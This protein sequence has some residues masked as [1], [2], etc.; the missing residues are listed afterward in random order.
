MAKKTPAELMREAREDAKRTQAE[1]ADEIGVSQVAVAKWE[2]GANSVD[3][4]RV[5]AVAKAYGLKPEQLIPQDE[6]AA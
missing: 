6:S 4:R 3:V 1:L 5:R 2:S